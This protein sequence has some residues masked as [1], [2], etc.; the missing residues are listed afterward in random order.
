MLCV[1]SLLLLIAMA[2][3]CNKPEQ[4]LAV[5]K[6]TVNHHEWEV[7][8]VTVYIKYQSK[9]FPGYNTRNYDDSIKAI[10]AE[11]FKAP[12]VFRNL[13]PGYYYLYASGFDTLFN[14][15]VRGYMPVQVSSGYDI[16]NVTLVVSE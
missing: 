11:R 4:E 5:I 3:S 7:P 8:G 1:V 10:S 16:K 15:P 12:F 14:M 9:E 2:T 6:G 13:Q